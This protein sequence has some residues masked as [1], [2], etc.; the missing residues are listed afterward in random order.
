M[1]DEKIV[2]FLCGEVAQDPE[3]IETLKL[4]KRNALEK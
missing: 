3:N 4:W 1:T 2:K